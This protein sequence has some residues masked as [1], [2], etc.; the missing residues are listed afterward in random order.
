MKIGLFGGSFNPIHWAH[1]LY[2]SEACASLGLTKVIFIPSNFSP[3]KKKEETLEARHRYNMVR[4]AVKGDRRFAVSD[5]EIRRGGPSY[6]I[7]TVRELKRR[8]PRASLFFL[9]GSDCLPTLNRWKEAEELFRLCRF[10][11]A[12][13]PG[14]RASPLSK[15]WLLLQIPA[16]D[17]SSR[18][19]RGRARRRR[20]IT[21]CVPR[22]VEEYILRHRL[23]R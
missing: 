12:Y 19:I 21:Y 22:T 15:K 17:L 2:A 7:E 10:V 13:R 18:Q 1:L 16:C 3:F 23:Y 5:I 11:V 4:L 9:I 14:F 6:T 8:M 20:P